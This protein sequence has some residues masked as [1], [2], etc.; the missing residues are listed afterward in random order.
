MGKKTTAM[1]NAIRNDISVWRQLVNQTG[2]LKKLQ[3]D[4]EVARD[5]AKEA[6]DDYYLKQGW[7]RNKPGR[8]EEMAGDAQWKKLS[9][10]YEDKLDLLTRIAQ[11][12]NRAFEEGK[13]LKAGI[14]AQVKDLEAYVAKKE[15]EKTFFW[16]KTSVSAAKKFIKE[17]KEDFDM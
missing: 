1:I 10:A 11:Q 15:K 16:Q 3:K 2:E 12:W 17:M 9:D 7:R 14:I 4:E 6:Y 5:K 8:E 13:K